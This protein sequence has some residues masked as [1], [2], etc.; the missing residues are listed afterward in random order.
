[1][2]FQGGVFFSYFLSYFD[3]YEDSVEPNFMYFYI[4]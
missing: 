1:L 3:L 4:M 2:E